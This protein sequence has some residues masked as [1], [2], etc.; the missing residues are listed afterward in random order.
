MTTRIKIDESYL[1]VR[2][3]EV[4]HE[5]GH[6]HVDEHKLGHQ[7]ENDEKDGR[8][9]AGHAAVADAVGRRIA[10]FSQSVLHDAVP[11][12]ARRHP[13]QGQKG[14]AK[15]GKVGVLPEPLARMIVVAF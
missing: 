14:D 5:D 4:F 12:V 15:V 8:D 3:L 13:K 11:V 2:L 10:V 6:D 1:F 7:D 9:D